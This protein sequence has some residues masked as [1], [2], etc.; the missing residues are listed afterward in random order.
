M[1][2]NSIKDKGFTLIELLV[3]IAII[4]LLASVVLVSLNST[5]KKARDT[6][7]LADINQI[8]KALA[9]Y[10]DA[11]G[12][13]PVH[14]SDA[15]CGAWD[16]T[17]DGTFLSV[18]KTAGYLSKDVLDPSINSSCQNYKY[19]RY[20]AGDSGCD[21]N[22]GAFYVIGVVDMETSSGAHP[23]NPGFSCSGRN[24]TG[25]FEWVTGQY[26]K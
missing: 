14:T 15:N 11:N 5:R 20:P 19:Y 24:W 22:K 25:E 8:Q 10:Y 1:Q 17:A 16:T 18:L 2:M 3:V 26:E 23:D 21:A 9:L 12:Q 13:Y 7:R 6:K 4:G